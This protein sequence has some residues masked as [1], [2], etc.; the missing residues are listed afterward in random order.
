MGYAHFNRIVSTC[1]LAAVLA[2]CATPA[3]AQDT[4]PP[5]LV[6]LDAG[7]ACEA[8]LANGMPSPL[9]LYPMFACGDGDW[10]LGSAPAVGGHMLLWHFDPP[11]ATYQFDGSENDFNPASWTYREVPVMDELC[12]YDTSGQHADWHVVCR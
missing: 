12:T 5:G 3:L 7:R 8:A 1:A 6:V 4:Q 10:L 9:G 11:P 2:L